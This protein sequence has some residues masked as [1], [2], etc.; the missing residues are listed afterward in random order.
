MKVVYSREFI[1]QAAELPSKII[2]KLD[3][4]LATLAKNP[5]DP[6]LHVKHL[7]GELQSMLSFRITRDWRVTFRF[8]EKV[9]IR[10]LGVKNRK[11]IYR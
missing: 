1:R 2:G 11:D 5:F 8:E 6:Q 7:K 4:L 9:I 10:I 3:S